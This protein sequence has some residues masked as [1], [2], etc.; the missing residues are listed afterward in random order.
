[1]PNY[2]ALQI[3]IVTIFNLRMIILLK[4]NKNKGLIVPQ[5]HR[6]I[7]KYWSVHKYFKKPPKP[8]NIKSYFFK[9]SD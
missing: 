4:L 5:N 8:L 7:S 3:K 9:T 1:M 2:D 6:E